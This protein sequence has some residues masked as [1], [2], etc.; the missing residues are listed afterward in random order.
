VT[1]LI[2][3]MPVNDRCDE[4]RTSRFP[5]VKDLSILA[6]IEHWHEGMHR[7][8]SSALHPPKHSL[9]SNLAVAIANSCATVT[10]HRLEAASM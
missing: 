4:K 5:T 8:L 3:C 7:S 1:T 6:P 10:V 9:G 2:F